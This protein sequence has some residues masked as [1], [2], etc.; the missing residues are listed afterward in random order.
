MSLDAGPAGN[1]YDKYRTRNPIAR[2]LMQGFLS[3]FDRLSSS[4][5]PGPVLEVG[6]GEGE[7]SMRLAARGH[8]VRGCDVSADV[9]DEARGRARSAGLAVEF[10]QCDIQDLTEH[11]A[12][13]L[14][15]CCEVLEHLRDP[16]AGLERLALLARPWLIVSVPREPLWRAMN[17]A[18][19]K[20]LG[21]LGNTPGHLNHWGRRAFLSQV[22]ERFD[23]VKTASPVPWTMA[24]C[25]VK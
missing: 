1:Y 9:I 3:G 25:K 21:Q 20:Y 14:V 15:I 10:W 5:P 23:I 4:I 18:R 16:Q 11:D 17:M 22:G 8:R 19:G 13:P 7:L 6:C 2:W 12:A 24:L